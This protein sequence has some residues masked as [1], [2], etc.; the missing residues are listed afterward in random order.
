MVNFSNYFCNK[1]ASKVNKLENRTDARE[2]SQDRIQ[3]KEKKLQRM[4]LTKLHT[5]K[6]QFK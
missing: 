2:N 6:F 1:H 4:L 5:S 3:G